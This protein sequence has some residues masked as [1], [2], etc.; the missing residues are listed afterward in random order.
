[1]SITGERIPLRV[2][3]NIAYLWNVDGMYRSPPRSF[4]LHFKIDI[5]TLRSKY[6]ICG[7]LTGTLPHLSQQN[8]FLGI[9]LVLLPEEVV[10]LVEKG[11]KLFV[12]SQNAEPC[13]RDSSHCK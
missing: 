11:I 3:N 7:I 4:H 5:A 2:S 1:M 10:L 6:H 8:V 13:S 12:V 9:P